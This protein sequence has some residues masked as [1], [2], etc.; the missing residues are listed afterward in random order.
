[1]ISRCS[2]GCSALSNEKTDTHAFVEHLA[3]HADQTIA[4]L[5]A[6]LGVSPSNTVLRRTLAQ[7]LASVGRHAE[8]ELEH[9]QI[10]AAS[11]EDADAK[12]ALAECYHAQGKDSH[13]LVLLDALKLRGQLEGKSAVLAARL[14]L[15]AGELA[16]AQ[17]LYAG[18]VRHDPSVA[19][20]D[21][22]RE[23]GLA[24]V[25]EE[26]VQDEGQDPAEHSQ[27]H[28]PP[29][30]RPVE[31]EGRTGAPIEAPAICFGDVG[32][33]EAVK[34]EITMKI[35][36]PIRHPELYKAYGKVG[37]G[38]ILMYGPPGCGKTMLARATAGEMKA[39]FIAVGIHD[40]LD[41]WIGNSERNMHA[42]FEMARRRAPCVLFFDEVD[43]L[44]AQRGD[45]ANASSRS[46]INQFLAEMDGVQQRNDGVLVLG[47]TNAPWH[48][49]SAF[50]RPGRFD[51]IL[52]VPPPD[53]SA[54][55]SILRLH[56][57]GKPQDRIDVARLAAKTPK[58]SGADLKAVV[59]MALESC[60]KAALK[61][62]KVSPVKQRDL[63]DALDKV[64]PSTLEWFGS[65]RN[66]ATYANQ[67]GVYDDVLHYLAAN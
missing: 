46:S 25:D 43:A 50:R 37:G 56:L 32:G 1:V 64:K 4:A 16:T 31:M 20:A 30:A 66:Y 8:A 35:I 62:G 24:S 17:V 11:P 48:L 9:R 67:G 65:A 54:R 21:L 38:G 13:A 61:S 7:L 29:G 44:G 12:L 57:V 19:D 40:V 47:A 28:L 26:E 34:D 33:M 45:M 36:A 10:L 52:F 18:A 53:A 41:M 15:R 58:Y 3:M 2:A 22:A 27:L 23:L 60:L 14:H 49:D 55:E 5:R 42:L 6:A 59:D 39:S 51:R 63:E